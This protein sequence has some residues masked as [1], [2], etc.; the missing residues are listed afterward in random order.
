VNIAFVGKYTELQ[1][2][3]KSINEALEHAGIKHKTRVNINFVLAETITSRNVKKLIGKHDAGS[4][5]WRFWT[6]RCRR[7]DSGLQICKGKS[8]PLF[9]YLSRYA[10]S[11]YRVL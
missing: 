10:G 4:G 3:Y 6:K 2:S 7:Y 1:D 11:N 8:N 5:A 9:R